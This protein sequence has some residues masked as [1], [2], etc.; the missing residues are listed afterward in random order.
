MPA[1]CPAS[2]AINSQ[3]AYGAGRDR[4]CAGRTGPGLPRCRSGRRWR[5]RRRDGW[6]A[7]RRCR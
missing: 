5:W 3:A 2:T 7:S 6:P 1:K 4:R